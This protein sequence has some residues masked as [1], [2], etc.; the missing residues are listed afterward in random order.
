MLKSEN[1]ALLIIDIQGNLYQSMH[2]KEALRENLQKLIRGTAALDIPV[3][4][5]EQVPEKLGPSIPE[6]ASLVDEFHPIPKSSFSCCGEPRFTDRL[7]KTGRRH[8]LVAG[9]ESHV[10]VYQTAADLLRLGYEAHI[11]TDCISS[12]TAENRHAGIERMIAE[13]GRRASM[14]MILFELLRAA[15]G[16][17][18]RTIAKIVK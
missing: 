12:R 7:G 4:V 1:A 3:I 15:K 14:E 11:I 16:D 18:F 2:E 6:I 10:C 17:V 13:G 8:I 9:I 5:T